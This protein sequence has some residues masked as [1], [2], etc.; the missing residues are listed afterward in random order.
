MPVRNSYILPDNEWEFDDERCSVSNYLLP[1]F[2][3]EMEYEMLLWLVGNCL[4]DPQESAHLV[5]LYGQG[6]TGKSTLMAALR[7]LLNGCCRPVDMSELVSRRTTRVAPEV[8]EALASVRLGICGYVDFSAG[9]ISRHFVNVAM[10]GDP[11]AVPPFSATIRSSVMV[12]TETLPSLASNPG[13]KSEAVQRRVRV[14]PMVANARE[15]PRAELPTDEK[16]H[17]H[18][19][20][21]CLS[22][23]LAYDHLPMSPR[24][25]LLSLFYNSYPVGAKIVEESRSAT[26]KDSVAA[27][28]MLATVLGVDMSWLSDLLRLYGPNC[29]IT[30]GGTNYIKGIKK[31][32]EV[33]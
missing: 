18:W 22:T 30:V 1:L 29:R 23:R 2:R 32:P 10:G 24:A 5:I 31:R 3:N 17:M 8:V 16:S 25:V 14:L 6:G 9:E 19:I 26:S 21:R 7:V 12:G 4:L 20:C 33:V 11:V 15:L 13:L 28:K 27:T